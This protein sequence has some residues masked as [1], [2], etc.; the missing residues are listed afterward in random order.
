[1]N[2]NCLENV[3]IPAQQHTTTQFSADTERAPSVQEKGQGKRN[4]KLLSFL[5][6]STL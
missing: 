5:P 4:G 1:M 6:H 2:Y 3:G